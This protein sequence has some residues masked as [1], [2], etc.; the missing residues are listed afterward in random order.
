MNRPVNRR[1]ALGA[2]GTV[3]VGAL[4]AACGGSDTR[5]TAQVPTA[6]GSTAI[7]SPQTTPD[8]ATAD[9]FAGAASC[10]LARQ[11]TA[12]PY[13]F[14]VNSIRSDLREDRKGTPLR[15][16]L[17]VQDT[18]KCAPLSNAVVDIW[19][20]DAT[21]LYS[22]YESASS[23]RGS[24]SGRTDEE[25]YLRGA[26]VTNSAGIVQFMTIYPGWYRGRTVHI[27]AKVHLDSATVLT[28]QFF[29]DE[30]VTAAVYGA[31]PYRGKGSPDTPNSDD[32]IYQESLR[33][34]ARKDGDGYLGIMTI[35]VDPTP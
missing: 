32:G 3:G 25:T 8:Q 26:Q 2:L 34:T 20:C 30:A 33:L 23:G 10:T 19:H 16:A 9:L 12:G 24:G 13:Y 1:H 7:V 18:E 35:G 11:L 17:R 21:G 14:D 27:H 29:F 22:G 31:D 5:R 6:E 4:L 28:T 15:L